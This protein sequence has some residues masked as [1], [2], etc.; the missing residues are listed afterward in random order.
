[1]PFWDAGAALTTGFRTYA[2]HWEFNG[3][4]YG[5]LRSM[6]PPAPG[7]PSE[8]TVRADEATRAIL[9]AAGV[10]AI[11]AI[12]LRARSAGAAAFAAVVAFLLASPTVFP[13]YAIPAVALLPLHPDLG[14]LVFSG[15]LA[16]SYVPLPHLRATGQWELP[17]WIL[18]VEYG[19]LVAA[20]ALAIA[21]RLGRRRSD[22][23]GGPNPP[24]EAAAQEREEAWTRDITP[25]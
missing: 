20:W 15:L 9:A 21:F 10:V 1:A 13:W 7:V 12:G 23:A 25:T 6:I 3:A 17:P 18:W 11:L 5:I 2:R 4:A 16:L 24:A 19:G 22:S 14:M 8:A